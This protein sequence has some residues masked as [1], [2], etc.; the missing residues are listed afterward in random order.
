M[1]YRD[2]RYDCLI[3]T[4][5]VFPQYYRRARRKKFQARSKVA[6]TQAQCYT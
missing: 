3:R 4:V 2:R 5:G 1:E 6:I